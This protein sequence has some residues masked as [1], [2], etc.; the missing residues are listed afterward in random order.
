MIVTIFR[1]GEAGDAANDRS[2]EL[3]DSGRDDIAFACRQF[4][5]ACES[6]GLLH[7]QRIFYSPWT[8]TLQTAEILAAAFT[9]AATAETKA[10]RPG[11]TT[12]NVDA[13]LEKYANPLPAD[14][15]VLLVSHQPLVS[16]LID[17][18]LGERGR[19][20]GLTPGGLAT[21]RLDVALAGC[22]Q[23]LFWA[24]PPE[25]EAGT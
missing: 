25:Y 6:R 12:G 13:A 16:Q 19:V 5:R 2:R 24:L 3:T 22:G 14:G 20:P 23:L 8:R 17:H 18:Y 21:L 9:H 11:S 10:L 4:H 7:P 15:H 1:H